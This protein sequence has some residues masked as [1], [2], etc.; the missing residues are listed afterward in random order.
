MLS[1]RFR[2]L[3]NKRPAPNQYNVKDDL[4]KASQPQYTFKKSPKHKKLKLDDLDWR[5]ALDPDHDAIRKRVP[6]AVIMPEKR[7]RNPRRALSDI[8]ANRLG[9][10]RYN[11]IFDLVEARN[12]K[13][14]LPYKLTP[15]NERAVQM[16]P[17]PK[18]LFDADL[19]P[20]YDFTKPRKPEFHYYEPTIW[21]PPHPSDGMLFK[22]RWRF[23]D[24]DMNK[25]RPEIKPIDFAKNLNMKEF[26]QFE[27]E[28]KLLEDYLQRRNKIP[29]IGHYNADFAQIDK[30]VQ[31]F[32]IEK[33]KDRAEKDPDINRD[34]L[35]LNPEKPK[36]K[37]PVFDFEKQKG[38][39]SKDLPQQDELL[40]QPNYNQIDKKVPGFVDFDKHLDRKEKE[41]DVNNPN[42]PLILEPKYEFTEAKIKG[43]ADFGKIVSRDDHPINK[44]NVREEECI[45]TPK[46]DLVKPFVGNLV[47]MDKGGERFKPN[48]KESE[49]GIEI[50][51]KTDVIQA[52]EA[53]KP[54]KNAMKF[55]GYAAREN[56]KKKPAKKK[57]TVIKGKNKK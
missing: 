22:E 2:P 52:Y 39:D 15:F 32:D 3:K 13:G 8:N 4:I 57:E 33:M 20:N 54:E 9:P 7:H 21:N 35:I 44:I 12:D 56:P 50:K 28:F 5:K 30:K 45:I 17:V 41:E 16:D 24:Y 46:E 48:T 53:S 23:Y 26:L 43:N 38:R 42:N 18:D 49:N 37:V 34:E 19:D 6:N 10:G 55:Q 47:Q 1:Y 27:Y 31:G 14:V 36:P 40:L 29:E 11:L 51:M 25:V